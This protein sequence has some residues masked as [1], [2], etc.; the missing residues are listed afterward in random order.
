MSA[1]GYCIVNDKVMVSVK[2]EKLMRVNSILTVGLLHSFYEQH[3]PNKLF[4]KSI[5]TTP[6]NICYNNVELKALSVKKADKNKDLILIDRTRYLRNFIDIL[7]TVC[8]YL[9]LIQ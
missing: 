5:L 4:A 3:E 8:S 1:K 7:F 9:F 2:N 6:T